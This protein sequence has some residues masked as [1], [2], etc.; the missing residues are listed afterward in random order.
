MST[1]NFSTEKALVFSSI[2]LIDAEP[3]V[4]EWQPV[5]EAG[6][7]CIVFEAHLPLTERK[8]FLERLESATEWA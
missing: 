8:V 1:E 6:Q 2:Q 3:V 5:P 4:S 7:T